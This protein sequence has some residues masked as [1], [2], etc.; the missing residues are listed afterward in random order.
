MFHIKSF[1]PQLLKKWGIKQQLEAS[2]VCKIADRI[3]KE[4]F[5]AKC[6]K[7]TFFRNGIIQIKCQNSILANEIRLR[8]EIIKSEINQEFAK[9]ILKDIFIK[10]S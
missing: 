2:E 4:A 9:E 6:A 1:I 3:I 5:G 7:A 8:K 10:I